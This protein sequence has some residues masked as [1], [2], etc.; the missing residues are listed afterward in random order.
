MPVGHRRKTTHDIGRG[1]A[2]LAL[3]PITM[4]PPVALANPHAALAM[5]FRTSLRRVADSLQSKSASSDFPIK[6]RT[7][8]AEDIFCRNT[9]DW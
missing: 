4:T 3:S 8:C 1:P 9:L 6:A 2:P 5:I 7:A